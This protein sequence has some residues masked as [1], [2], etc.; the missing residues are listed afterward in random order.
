M[1]VNERLLTSSMDDFTAVKELAN[2]K[3]PRFVFEA[4]YRM[5]AKVGR[6]G[7]ILIDLA[8]ISESIVAGRM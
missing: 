1:V 2:R 3:L 6:E 5:T 8:C 4:W 7:F